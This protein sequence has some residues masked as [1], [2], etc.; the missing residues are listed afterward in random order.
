MPHCLRTSSPA[1]FDPPSHSQNEPLQDDMNET[2]TRK[3]SLKD[4]LAQ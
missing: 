1:E 4:T 2:C 3:M